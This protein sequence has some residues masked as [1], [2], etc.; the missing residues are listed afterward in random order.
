MEKARRRIGH[1]GQALLILGLIEVLIGVGSILEPVTRPPGTLVLHELIPAAWYGCAWMVGGLFAAC[2]MFADS[3]K[4]RD[5][6][7]FGLLFIVPSV[8]S[9]SFYASWGLHMIGQP[10]Y[11]RGWVAGSVYM[12]INAA[13]WNAAGWPEPA[14]TVP[15][16]TA[17][18]GGY[19]RRRA[20]D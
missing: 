18:R 4:G 3:A 15:T 9:L 8:T 11:T 20:S 17:P 12:L 1:R 13:V 14:R 5:K 6:L 19:G 16:F 10:G 7:G 2:F